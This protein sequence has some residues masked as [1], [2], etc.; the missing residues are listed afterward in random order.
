MT[1]FC[2]YRGY[3]NV[4]RQP[5]GLSKEVWG[6]HHT[7]WCPPS[8]SSIFFW[9]GGGD[10]FPKKVLPPN[11]APQDLAEVCKRDGT[12][13][14]EKDV[15]RVVGLGSSRY[16]EA[17]GGKSCTKMPRFSAIRLFF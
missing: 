13:R 9:G 1:C 3:K 11:F 8:C 4:K 16:G 5:T 14:D 17:G 10:A 12:E 2:F 6:G 15:D 7:W